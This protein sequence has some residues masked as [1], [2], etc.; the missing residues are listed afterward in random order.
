MENIWRA[1]EAIRTDA[2]RRRQPATYTY[3][4]VRRELEQGG[5]PIAEST[6]LNKPQGLDYQL[7]I[8]TYQEDHGAKQRAATD[9]ESLA[10]EIKDPRLQ[11]R[12]RIVLQQNRAL[13]HRLDVVHRD[14]N[15]LVGQSAQAA[16]PAAAAAQPPGGADFTTREVMAVRQFLD[17]IP[18]HLWQVDEA[19]G[20]ILDHREDEIAAPG[21]VH[22]LRRIAG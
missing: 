16:L 8:G 17:H 20:A 13:Q 19:S 6:I 1:L 9:E 7:L 22:A 10:L 3:A 5:T 12:I 2:A 18:D 14:Y 11:A 15:R 21:F 4:A